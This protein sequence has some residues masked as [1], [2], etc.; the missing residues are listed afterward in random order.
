MAVG[1]ASAAVRSMEVNSASPS[2]PDTNWATRLAESRG[3]VAQSG[4]DFL[5]LSP[6][7]LPVH[8]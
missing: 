4:K 2:P 1:T 8:E 5:Q 6:K 3:R 7:F